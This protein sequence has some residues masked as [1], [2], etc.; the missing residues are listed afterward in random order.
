MTLDV[1][2]IKTFI[3][4]SFDTIKLQANLPIELDKVQTSLDNVA[5]NIVIAGN[6]NINSEAFTGSLSIC[7]LRTYF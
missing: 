3:K 7:F 1:N 5:D 2:F 6:L 4:A